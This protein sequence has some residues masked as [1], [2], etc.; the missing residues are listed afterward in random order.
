MELMTKRSLLRDF[1]DADLPAFE[2]Y[3]ADP[4][5]LE[6][7]GT[8]EVNPGHARQLIQL[9]RAWAT[10]QPRH[11]FQVAIIRRD[12]AQTLI[13]C[14]G[15]RSKDSEPG[16]AELGVELAPE[17]WGRFGYAIEIMRSLVDFGFADLGLRE[18]Y[19]STVSANTKIWRL[20]T[21]FAAVAVE[22]PTPA[23]MMAKGWR[24]IEWQ[25]C[26]DQWEQGRLT[27]RSS[28]MPQVASA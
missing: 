4:R 10:E 20:A 2:A 26:R 1:I 9:F 12:D 8:D 28:R 19:G 14:C 3:H 13:G 15:L 5:S 27:I 21:S 7:Y 11:N 24:Q 23:W 18:I 17:Y 6:S 16:K 22:R 25:I